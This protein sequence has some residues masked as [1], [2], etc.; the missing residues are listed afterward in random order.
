MKLSARK[1]SRIVGWFLALGIV[2]LSLVPPGLRP[3]TGMPHDLEHF[4]IFFATGFSFGFG[5][6]RRPFV[7]MVALVVFAGAVELAQLLVSG[8]HARFSDFIVD[9][10]ALCIGVAMASLLGARTL[11]PSI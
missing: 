4:I 8:R 6:G 5:Y 7:A 11:A 10:L 1:S 3:E 2:V 9:A